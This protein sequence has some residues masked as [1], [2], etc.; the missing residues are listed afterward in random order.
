MTRHQDVSE[1]NLDLA[2]LF[3]Q[4]YP[5]IYTYLRYRVNSIED[6]EDLISAIFEQAFRHRTQ[7]DP[8]RGVFSTWLFRIAHNELVSYYR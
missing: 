1:P 5:P 2:N 3:Q 4:H 7:F 8:T 6:A